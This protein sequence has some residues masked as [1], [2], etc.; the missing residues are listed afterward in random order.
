ME[1]KLEPERELTY[2]GYNRPSC[3]GDP[4]QV[5]QEKQKGIIKP[6]DDCLPCVW[7]KKCFLRARQLSDKVMP[8]AQENSSVSRVT[9]FLKRW[10]SQKAEKLK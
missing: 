10:S 6:H 1:P 9:G 3:F 5:F 8:L 7:V 4:D 2:R